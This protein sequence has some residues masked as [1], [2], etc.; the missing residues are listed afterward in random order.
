MTSAGNTEANANVIQYVADKFGIEV[1]FIVEGDD[2]IIATNNPLFGDLLRNS[3]RTLGMDLV[4]DEKDSLEQ[5]DFCKYNFTTADDGTM[6]A[7]RD[8]TSTLLKLGWDDKHRGNIGQRGF[9]RIMSSKLNSLYS[10][11]S[12]YPS[13]VNLCNAIQS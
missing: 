7:Y 13:M 8:V 3:A 10:E 2:G 6:H 11:Y 9:E 1:K 12:C 4:I 5:V